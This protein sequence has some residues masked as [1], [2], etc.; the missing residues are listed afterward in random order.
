MR[1]YGIKVKWKP[2]LWFVKGDFRR[3]RETWVDDL[4]QSTQEK[5]SHPWQQSVVEARY[6]IDTLTRKGELV[7]DPFCGGG[8][9][10]VAAKQLG[11]QWWTADR[12]SVHVKTAMERLD[13]A[14][15]Q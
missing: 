3:D 12:E 7:V 1:E 8:T 6:Y 13:D 11:R 5:D 9:T 2:M 10:A 15:I 14:I 4:V